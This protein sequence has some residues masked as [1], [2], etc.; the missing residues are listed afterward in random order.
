MHPIR[1]AVLALLLLL[2]SRAPAQVS[3]DG[4]DCTDATL[5]AAEAELARLALTMYTDSSDQA[6]FDACRDLI[7]GLVWVLRRENSFAYPFG[8]VRGLSIQYPADSS[9]RIFSWELH[10]NRDE[11]RH[12]GAV[13][14]NTPELQLFPLIDRGFALREN[15]ENVTLTGDNWLGYAVYGIRA[16]GTHRG[17]PYW[18]LFGYDSD[19]AYRQKKVLDV[20]AF[21]PDGKPV[22][23][24]PVFDTYTPQGQPLPDRR[25]LI[26][27]YG[28]E[29]TAALR[30]D[31]DLGAIVYENLVLGPGPNG[32][33]PVAMP[34]GSYH[35]LLPDGQG[36]WRERDRVF[37]GILTEPPREA[38]LPKDD[39]DILG[40][41]RT[42]EPGRG[43]N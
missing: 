32:E 7:S 41:A 37:E 24:L 25:R 27:E 33:G 34:D 14:M 11:Y 4:A 28:A 40:R 5:A 36:R 31:P 2:C 13:Q 12:Y 39:R 9:F 15:P 26:L 30:Y 3:D 21:G 23:G 8:E 10:V 6:R 35:A 19:S 17:R 38:P 22:F 16:G 43:N 18:F 42:Q 20:L 29:A 1:L